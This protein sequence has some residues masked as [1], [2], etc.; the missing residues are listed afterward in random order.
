MWM[1]G[2]ST[3]LDIDAERR[4]RNARDRDFR[5]ASHQLVARHLA[6]VFDDA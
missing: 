3:Y 2:V 6:P 5:G 1:A 4:D